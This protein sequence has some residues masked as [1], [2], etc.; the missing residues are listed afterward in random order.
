[1]THAYRLALRRT[2][3]YSMSQAAG[4]MRYKIEIMHFVSSVVEEKS[5]A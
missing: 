2:T 3:Y 5:H 4:G 1:M